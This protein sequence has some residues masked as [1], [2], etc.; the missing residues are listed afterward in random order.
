MEVVGDQ[1]T[2]YAEA[3]ASGR[4]LDRYLAGDAL[5]SAIQSSQLM[6]SL[7]YQQLGLA[8]FQLEQASDGIASGCLDLSRVVIVDRS[9][10]IVQPNR[11]EALRFVAQYDLDFRISNLEVSSP[12]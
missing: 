7:G 8:E 11:P 9:G 4:G 2:S 10:E 6:N 12:C 1:L 3:S 5:A